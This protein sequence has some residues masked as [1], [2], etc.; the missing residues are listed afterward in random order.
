MDD[1][2][3]VVLEGVDRYRVVDPMFEGVRIVLAHRGETYSPAYV[4][5]ISGAAFRIGG[6]CPC[7]PT[8]D[9]AMEPQELIQ[10]LGYEATHLPLYQIGDDEGFDL[11]RAADAAIGRVKEELRA[12]RPALAWHAFT[13]CEWD[14][15]AG[16]DD[17]GSLFFGR[18][19]HA[20]IDRYAEADQRRTITCL[21]ICPAVGVMLV[22]EKVGVFNA[23]GAEIA[24][25][26]EAVR[27]AHSTEGQDRLSGDEWVMLYGLLCYDRW[28]D[29]WSSPEK[30]RTAGD[31]Y[32][33]GVYRS[34]HR[35][36]AGFL[37]EVAPW[38]PTA[39]ADLEVAARA[40][41]EEAHALNFAVPLLGWDAPEGPDTDRNAQL[42]PLLQRARDAYARGIEGIERA[43]GA[44]GMIGI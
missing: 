7:A 40:F 37:R 19:S 3:R 30:V 27:H 43:L 5:G 42:V 6:I 22:G 44:M 20:G 10:L 25:L 11:D 33:L 18:G 34:T 4:Q 15:V 17:E 9:Y 26:R 8:C 14:V 35:A 31:S 39:A 23:R 41:I 36:A 24:A 28:V 2:V 38:Y 16:F 29:D 21:E 12:G 1:E 32:C 13:N